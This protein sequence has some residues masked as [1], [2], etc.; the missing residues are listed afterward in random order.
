V[1]F[2][3]DRWPLQ[4]NQGLKLNGQGFDASG[5]HFTLGAKINHKRLVESIA[6]LSGSGQ[7]FNS[8]VE[9]HAVSAEVFNS[10]AGTNSTSKKFERK[11]KTNSFLGVF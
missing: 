6:T 11:F 7:W 10:I 9:L 3:F 1:L 8:Y 2:S 4:E 5:N